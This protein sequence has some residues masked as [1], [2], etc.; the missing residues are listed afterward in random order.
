MSEWTGVEGKRVLITGATNGIGLSAAQKLARGGASL[1]IVARDEAKGRASVAQIEAAGAGGAPVD[2]LLA[3]LS[4]QAQVRR[5]AADALARYPR[6]DV[7]ANNAGAM[8]ARRSLTEDGIELSWALNHLAPFLLTS[9]L[10]ERLRESA[11]ARVITTASDAH[12]GTRI[13]FD[14]MA[15]ERSYSRGGF[16][17]YGQ[18]KLANILFTAELAQRLEGSG[19]SAYCFHPGLVATGFNRNNG[20]AMGALMYLARPLSRSPERGARTLVWL[21][22]SAEPDGQSGGYFTDEHLA[23]PTAEAQDVDVARRLWELS[24]E[25]T[26]VRA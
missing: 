12:R 2:L 11:P 20:R 23:T 6:I 16:T 5:L 17:R 10:Q 3:D 24:E 15:A 9:L 13:P 14:D 1:A 21:A 4:S 8:F 18:T 19:V 25:Q 7:L 26:Q 22:D